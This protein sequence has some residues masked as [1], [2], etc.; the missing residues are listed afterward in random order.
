MGIPMD[1]QC[2]QCQLKR[3]LDTA[4][5]LGDEATA[6]A[7]AKELLRLFAD[8]PEQITP[9]EMT[10]LTSALL[11]RFYD[12]EEDRFREEKAFSNQF[13]LERM[14]DIR[15]R[16]MNAPDPV[17][18]GLQ[19][20]ILG[21]YID[22]S[23]L[24]GQVSFE[25]LDDLLDSALEMELDKSVYQD[26]LQDLQKGQRVLYLTD[27]AGEIGFDRIFGEVLAKAF[28]HLEITYCVRGGYAMNDATRED[29]A[30]VGIPFPVIDNGITV[31]GTVPER[32]SPEAKKAF[33]EADVIIA[34]GQGNAE[35]LLGCGKNIYY[36][37][38]IKCIR[39]QEYYNKPK[40]TPMFVK[41]Q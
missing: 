41:E 17:F 28:P 6:I 36:A 29:A 4:R 38:L 7:F 14:D 8:A 31:P 22:F 33:E 20:S 5:G 1:T 16:V 34:K 32:I 23:A 35:T 18:A 30:F 12:L 27:N 3:N 24:H 25:Q 26:F 10:P 9:P 39:F 13:V 11:Q 19:F 37:F 21:N 2:L 15:C 40:L